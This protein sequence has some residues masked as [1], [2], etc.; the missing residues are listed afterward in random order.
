[1]NTGSE[2]QIEAYGAGQLSRCPPCFFIASKSVHYSRNF[3]CPTHH[4]CPTY[5]KLNTVSVRKELSQP[6]A[7]VKDS[8]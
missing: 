6:D 2:T 4:R 8:L 3:L 1:M 5:N 7:G